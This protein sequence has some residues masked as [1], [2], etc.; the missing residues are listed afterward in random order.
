MSDTGEQGMTPQDPA[1]QA[2][3]GVGIIPDD[4]G[5]GYEQA[6]LASR[7]TGD[8]QNGDDNDEPGDDTAAAPDAGGGA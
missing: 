2:G 8:D 6:A 3:V 5:E 7:R 4:Q 1:D